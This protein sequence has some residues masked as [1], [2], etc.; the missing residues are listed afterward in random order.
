[1]LLDELLPEIKSLA[2]LKVILVV[3]RA[4]IGWHEEEQ[5]LTFSDLRSSPA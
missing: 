5:K 3:V 4:T 2:E 1:V